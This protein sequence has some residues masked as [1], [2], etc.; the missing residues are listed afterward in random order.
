MAVPLEWDRFLATLL[1]K[2]NHKTVVSLVVS[3]SL[4][5]RV[6]DWQLGWICP[7]L[8]RPSFYDFDRKTSGS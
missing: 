1:N 5:T 7:N 8:E 2:I 3:S 4:L 6:T